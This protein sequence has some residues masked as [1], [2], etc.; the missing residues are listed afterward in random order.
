MTS[1][2]IDGLPKCF[3]KVW[4][5]AS[6]QF[7]RRCSHE[8]AACASLGSCH[9]PSGPTLGSWA[10]LVVRDLIDRACFPKERD[11]K[12]S[13]STCGKIRIIRRLHYILSQV[14]LTDVQDVSSA[15]FVSRH[16]LLRSCTLR[17]SFV[18]EKTYK[19]TRAVQLAA[20]G[21]AHEPQT[22][23]LRAVSVDAAGT[24]LHL[25]EPVSQVCIRCNIL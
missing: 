9:L 23:P 4:R 6:K 10:Q 5:G 16:V 8:C 18:Q 24:L 17:S 13:R 1:P 11:K 19:Q 12:F 15:I 7:H 21:G 2:A 25:S 14:I 20:V 3:L 22:T